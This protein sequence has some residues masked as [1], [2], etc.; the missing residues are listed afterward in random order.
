MSQDIDNPI[1]IPD[2]NEAVR[3]ADIRFS[4]TRQDATPVQALTGVSLMIPKGGYVVLIGRNGSGKSTLAKLINVLEVPDEGTLA[5]LG[6]DTMS[7][8]NFWYIRSH[9]GMV[10][11]NPDNQIVGTS[12]EEDV[13]FGPENLG[14]PTPE[15][16]RRVDDA[17]EYVGLPG[18]ADRMPSSLSGGQK[19]KLAIAGVLAMMP[20][21][22][23]LDE[24][25]AM[26]DPISRN[27]FL[28]LVE[29][30]RLEK[31]ITVIHI[32]HD[33]SEAYRAGHV[34]V[35]EKGRI[36]M[37]GSPSDVFIR[38]EQMTKL[39]LDVPVFAGVVLELCRQLGISPRKEYLESRDAALDSVRS[40]FGSLTAGQTSL[41]KSEKPAEPKIEADLRDIVLQVK[42]LSYS[43]EERSPM[44]L[45][46]ISFSVKRGEVYSV[47]G[48]SGSGKTTLISH[49]NGLIR[50]QKGEVE[51]LD[52]KSG[53]VW[54]TRK[55]ADVKE[56]RRRIGLLFQY[57]EYQ[58]FEETVRKD[59]LFG[60]LKMGMDKEAAEKSLMDAIRL[61]GLD[62]SYLDRSPFELSGGQKRRVAFAGVIAMDPEILVLDEPAAGLDPVGRRDVF[63]YI[64]ELKNLGKT[65]ILVS[66]NMD[67]AARISDRLLVLS[68]GR[69]ICEASPDEL[70]SSREKVMDI[71]L[72]L[73]E[74]VKFLWELAPDFP[75][76][77]LS[78]YD[79]E[80][81]AAELIRAAGGL[82][83]VQDKHLAGETDAKGSRRGG[84]D[85]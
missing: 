24:S 62:E 59:I 54:N 66:H 56:M 8:E 11:Q 35:L 78:V 20:Q 51:L 5:V 12:V 1:K 9:C 44:T 6:L 73:P 42:N 39:G 32:T 25:T 83:A 13:A 10:F 74:S 45:M 70:F 37:E 40:I 28:D 48:H 41:V 46:D 58:L 14:I 47:I 4:Y 84:R 52:P 49:L 15:I 26:L 27:E 43:Y 21:V 64:R 30:L 34:F 60:P 36:V 75:G 76:L 38:H 72:D 85:D 31:G 16:R 79:V 29:R 57:P 3:G 80:Q 33:M 68:E 19:Q 50:P 67:E 65:I 55:N 71:G 53:T 18:L 7:E 69:A 22:L 17:L 23:I 82:S 61:V 77:D 81:V 63:R 2:T